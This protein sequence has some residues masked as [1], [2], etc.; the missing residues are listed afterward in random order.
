MYLKHIYRLFFICNNSNMKEM[1]WKW[2]S[3]PAKAKVAVWWEG[4][5][6]IRWGGIIHKQSLWI[7]ASRF[8]NEAISY[9]PVAISDKRESEL[10]KA[11]QIDKFS[12]K[13]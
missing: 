2:R 11:Y 1:C 8:Q 6:V 3:L 13:E 5:E 12:L 9:Q 7:R 4:E 10:T